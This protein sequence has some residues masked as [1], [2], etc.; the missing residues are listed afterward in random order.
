MSSA[1]S[2][3]SAVS[4]GLAAV[5]FGITAWALRSFGGLALVLAVGSSAVVLLRKVPAV[6]LGA[7][8][9]LLLLGLI[10][11]VDPAVDQ[12]DIWTAV[13]T[14]VTAW[15]L[16]S[17]APAIRVAGAA[18]LGLACS[19][20]APGEA[21]FISVLCA[22]LA[23]LAAAGT[24]K[25][26]HAIAAGRILDAASAQTPAEVAAQ[27][28]C[29]ERSR[30]AAD[31]QAVVR[32]SLARMGARA[33]GASR[34]VGADHRPAAEAHLL[35][36]E[37]EGRG[38]ITEMRR[39]LGLLTDNPA[40]DPGPSPPADR[41]RDPGSDAGASTRRPAW[42]PSPTWALAGLA[43]VALAS[44]ELRTYAAETAQATGVSIPLTFL[45]AGAVAL[46]R[47]APQWACLAVGSAYALGALT[48]LPVSA[49]LWYVFAVGTV[50][51]RTAA[52]AAHA[53]AILFALIITIGLSTWLTDPSNAGMLVWIAFAV[54]LTG[55][56]WRHNDR[57]AHRAHGHTEEVLRRQ[58]AAALVAVT[59]ERRRVARELHDV[60]SHAI[61]LMVVQ[62]GA[63]AA[64]LDTDRR[65][66]DAAIS[67]VVRAGDRALREADQLGLVI[68]QGA[69]GTAGLGPGALQR[70]GGDICDLVDRVA[71]VGLHVTLDD[72]EQLLAEIHGDAAV[73]VYRVVQEGLTNVL[74]HAP[75]ATVRVSMR[76]A[77]AAIEVELLDDGARAAEHE[78]IGHRGFGLIGL[79][80]R[81]RAAGGTLRTAALHPHGFQVIA[82]VP[83]TARQAGLAS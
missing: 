45:A 11:G 82:T 40:T 79:G 36:V 16:G 35:A 28:V 21:G 72:P 77:A 60:L 61:T 9:A 76:T 29:D 1:G 73:C 39:L 46:A 4:L 57:A 2:A 7:C 47:S 5:A 50:I 33:R 41:G 19:G 18:L 27:A 10:W 59:A 3:R 65:A 83:T 58:E 32:G 44:V 42:L 26:H 69:A 20:G 78:P 54:A 64:L 81:V 75:D 34:E 53:P 22:G 31:V 71:G 80:D 12:Y 25:R 14:L 70:S 48:G 52:G 62:A 63:A 38:A 74:R 66:A 23:F 43:A 13:P 51:W 56:A 49:G 6:A 37:E 68:E 8:V 17:L 15:S 24:A 55:L 30:I 67:E